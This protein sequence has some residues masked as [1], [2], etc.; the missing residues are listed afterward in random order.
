MAFCKYDLGLISKIF[1]SIGSKVVLLLILLYMILN[2]HG[3]QNGTR[4]Q[5]TRC[6][7]GRKYKGYRKIKNAKNKEVAT[8]V[9]HLLRDNTQVTNIG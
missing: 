9:S 7:R 3:S 8:S 1:V 6:Q 5:K 4:L 2:Y